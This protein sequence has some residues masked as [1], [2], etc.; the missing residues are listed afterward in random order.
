MKYICEFCNFHLEFSHSENNIMIFD[1][2]NCP[3]LI[4]FSFDHNVRV[5]TVFLLDRNQQIYLW[6]INYLTETSYISSAYYDILVN[7]K[8]ADLVNFPKIMQVSPYNIYQKF[9]LYMTFL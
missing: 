1:C 4:S 6:T 7:G 9:N 3:M 2:I 8:I 5:K